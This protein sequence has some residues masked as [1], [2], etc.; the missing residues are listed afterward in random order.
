[1]KCYRREKLGVRR[2]GHA[3]IPAGMHAQIHGFM[4]RLPADHS[5]WNP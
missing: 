4:A 3:G 2:F 5:G 1:M